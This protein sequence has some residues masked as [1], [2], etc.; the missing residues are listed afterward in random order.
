MLLK[1][2]FLAGMV[3][4]GIQIFRYLQTGFRPETCRNDSFLGFSKSLI[5][6]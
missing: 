4:S 2:D 3:L 6:F 1:K 5:Y